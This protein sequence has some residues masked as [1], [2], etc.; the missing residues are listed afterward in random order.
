MLRVSSLE[1]SRVNLEM[2]EVTGC[3]IWKRV[4]KLWNTMVHLLISVSSMGEK[5][6]HRLQ[7]CLKHD[8]VK[9]Y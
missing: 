4:L 7:T 6:S 9:G 3:E 2:V 1:G 8:T 5:V